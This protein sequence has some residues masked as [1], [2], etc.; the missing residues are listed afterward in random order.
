MKKAMKVSII[1][2]GKY[3]K[4]LVFKGRKMKTVGGLKK[5]DLVKS[6]FGKI[7]SKKK[8]LL[9]KKS[10]WMVAVAKARKALGLK[11]FHVIGGKSASGQAFLKKAKSF[12]K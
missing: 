4:S 2:K 3:A 1:G 7:V 6:K 9:G 8:S 5:G 10:K 12:Y 11:G